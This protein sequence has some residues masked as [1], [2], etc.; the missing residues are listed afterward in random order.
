L[1]ISRS[2]QTSV[3]GPFSEVTARAMSASPRR[4]GT[5]SGWLRPKSARKE[6]H[7]RQ[8]I[9]FL[10]DHLVGAGDQRWRNREAERLGGLEVDYQFVLGRLLHRQLGWLGPF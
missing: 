9:V 6:T 10:L 8:Q 2:D 5:A 7:A 4:P 1:A 3:P